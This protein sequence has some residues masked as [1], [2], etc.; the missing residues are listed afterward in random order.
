[1][2][3]P[4]LKWAIGSECGYMDLVSLQQR[5]IELIDSLICKSVSLDQALVTSGLL[6]SLA[7]VN[8]VA[9]LESTFGIAID[10]D[11]ITLERF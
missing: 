7:T 10:F 3:S 11:E 6:D 9:S 5:I 4:I 1:M 2:M 8:L